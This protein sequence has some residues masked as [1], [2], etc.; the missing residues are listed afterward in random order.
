MRLQSVV[1]VILLCSHLAIA[2]GG[3]RKE[4]G[5]TTSAQLS[6]STTVIEHAYC[7]NGRVRLF[8][9]LTY[10]NVGSE[11]IILK[12]DSLAVGQ[13]SVSR[14]KDAAAKGKY[15]KVARFFYSDFRPNQTRGVAPP[16]DKFVIIAS[17]E[18]Y[19]VNTKDIFKDIRFNNYI[20]VAGLRAGTHFLQI[21]VRTWDEDL[22][23]AQELSLSWRRYGTLWWRGVTSQPMQ[24][25]IERSTSTL[26]CR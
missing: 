24:F 22:S 17:G 5:E 23:L 4:S 2:Q 15:E 18:S 12:R 19:E 16:N 1:G 26:T 25:V 14:S 7:S 21:S 9:K 6:L 20:D 8:L 10:V 3:S 11:P 13:L